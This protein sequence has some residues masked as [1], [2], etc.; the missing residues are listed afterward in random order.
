MIEIN[1]DFLKIILTYTYL[2][3]YL[4]Y[5][6]IWFWIVLGDIQMFHIFFNHPRQVTQMSNNIY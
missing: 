6:N 4:I 3:T 2:L 1:I 5:L